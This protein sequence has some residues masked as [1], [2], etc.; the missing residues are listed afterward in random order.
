MK[1]FSKIILLFIFIFTIIIAW[2]F[3]PAK[4]LESSEAKVVHEVDLSALYK[5][6]EPLQKTP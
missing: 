4:P 2:A 3:W 6:M 5:E 1:T